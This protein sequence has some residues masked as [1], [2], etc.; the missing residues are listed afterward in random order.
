MM[1]WGAVSETG[2][3]RLN[4]ED[5]LCINPALKLFAVADGMGG[6]VAGE[7][8]SRLALEVLE[9]SLEQFITGG[10]DVPEAL[11]AAVREANRAI[12]ERAAQD[13]QFKGMGTTLSAC[14]AQ[15]S[16]LVVAHVGDSRIYLVRGQDIKQLTEDHS[17]VRE[18]AKQGKITEDES[19]SHPY[20]NVLT[21]ALGTGTDLAV[22]SQVHLLQEGDR[23]V[24]CTDGL[25]NLVSDEEILARAGEGE[26]PARMA[27][28][29]A[30]L[31]LS[32]GGTDNVT[33]IV[34]V[35]DA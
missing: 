6:H 13:P 26:D 5:S 3:V 11:S 1:R 17:L 9:A 18:L 28:A 25:T 27:G 35:I 22:D 4:N 20:R 16:R 31:A 14:V 19:N 10:R 33:V 12:Y 8:A 23:L 2:M 32:R 21:R 7:V 24:L 15:G 30:E 34:V 29:L